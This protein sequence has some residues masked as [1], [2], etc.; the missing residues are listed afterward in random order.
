MR[1]LRSTPFK[2]DFKK[3]PLAIQIRAEKAVRLLIQ[4]PRHPSLEA[5]VVDVRRRI[6]KAKIDSGCRFTF[7][8]RLDLI[9][10]RR[11]GGA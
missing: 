10:L 6:W 8:I 9:I 7:E 3:L 1:V 2:R 11:L 5:R 4:N